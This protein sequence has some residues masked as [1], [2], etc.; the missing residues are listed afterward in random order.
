MQ[1]LESYFN[2]SSKHQIFK[3]QIGNPGVFDSN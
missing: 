2:W 1:K 3:R